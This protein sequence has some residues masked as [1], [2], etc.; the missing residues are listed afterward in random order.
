MCPDL[1]PGVLRLR[2]S[3]EN[4]KAIHNEENVQK[5]LSSQYITC[6]AA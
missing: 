3:L 6:V 5:Y 4:S 2:N 1:W